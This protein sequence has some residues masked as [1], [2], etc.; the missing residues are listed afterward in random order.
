MV[1]YLRSGRIVCGKEIIELYAVCG[2]IVGVVV[3][4]RELS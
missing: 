3:S 4:S 1:I 2:V